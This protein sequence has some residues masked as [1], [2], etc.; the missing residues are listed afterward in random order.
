RITHGRRPVSVH[1]SEVSMTVH[2]SISHRPVLSHIYQSSVDGAVAMGMIFTHGISD[3][4]GTF[5][6]RLIRPVVQFYH[7]VKN[8]SLHRLQS[9]P[10][11]G[12][13]TGRDDA[14][15][16]LDIGFLHCLLQIHL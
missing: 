16:I 15:G 5:S 9:V 3:D 14:H 4:T 8:P 2:Q 10:Y 11:I 12:K 13:G 1:G 7:G 6:V